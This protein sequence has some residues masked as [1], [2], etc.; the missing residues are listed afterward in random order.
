MELIY[1]KLAIFVFVLS[2]LT[3]TTLLVGSYIQKIHEEDSRTIIIN[4][5][6]QECKMFKEKNNIPASFN[7]TAS[8][9]ENMLGNGIQN[10]SEDTYLR[11]L[12]LCYGTKKET[13]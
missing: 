2:S 12:S 1:K 8:T 4:A 5:M 3:C 6:A 9:L 7:A 11:L 13:I 10:L